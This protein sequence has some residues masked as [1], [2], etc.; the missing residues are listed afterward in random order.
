MNN[1]TSQPAAPAAAPANKNNLEV[2]NAPQAVALRDQLA[3]IPFDA[4]TGIQIRNL[5][6]ATA[7]AELLVRG[8]YAPKGASVEYAAVA[9]IQ[10]AL[11]GLN[12]IQ[13]LQNIAVVNGRP[14]L[15]GDGL[16]AIV[17][18]S[19]VY[20]GE[21]IEWLGKGAGEEDAGCR[22]T[23]WRLLPNGEKQETVEWFTVSDAKRA[24]LWDKL[25]PWKQYPRRMLRARATAWA[26]REAFP[27]VLQGVRIYEEE[28]DNAMIDVQVETPAA[29]PAS[30]AAV[31]AAPRGTKQAAR[32]AGALRIDRP[33][34]DPAPP[35]ALDLPAAQPKEVAPVP[36]ATVTPVPEEQVLPMDLPAPEKEPEYDRA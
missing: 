27:D 23:V 1:I 28:R 16:A 22:V 26:Y 11:L 8:G 9:I 30:R 7:I 14:T 36:G 20:G 19:P 25:G 18:S 10:G 3:S 2:R 33:A 32:L 29:A 13:A 31:A 24:G 17:K 6:N 21:K 5:G 15:F 34:P 4:K 35:V 12:P